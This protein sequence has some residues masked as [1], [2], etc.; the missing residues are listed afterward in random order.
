MGYESEYGLAGCLWLK[1]THEVVAHLLTGLQ[2]YLKVLL[3]EGLECSLHA[4]WHSPSV[5]LQVRLSG[6]LCHNITAGFPRVSD[7]RKSVRVCLI[8]RHTLSRSAHIQCL[9][10]AQIERPRR[11]TLTGNTHLPAPCEVVL[12]IVRPA[13]QF[14]FFPLVNP[15][16]PSF[17]SW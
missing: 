2:S 13:S 1:V 16:F 12:G 7:P 4:D 9:N 5:L 17:R 11:F 14:S 15:A 10:K 6:K 3:Y 8:Q